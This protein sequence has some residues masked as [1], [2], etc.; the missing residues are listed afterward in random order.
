MNSL[1]FWIVGLLT[2]AL[3][4]R[5]L[6]LSRGGATAQSQTCEPTYEPL[7]GTRDPKRQFCQPHR[8]AGPGKVVGLV[9]SRRPRRVVEVPPANPPHHYSRQKSKSWSAKRLRERYPHFRKTKDRNKLR[10]QLRWPELTL[11]GIHE[12]RQQTCHTDPPFGV[13]NSGRFPLNFE[14]CVPHA[15]GCPGRALTISSRPP[16]ARPSRRQSSDTAPER[17]SGKTFGTAGRVGTSVGRNWE[18]G[19][20]E[21]LV[22]RCCSPVGHLA[23]LV[24][25]GIC[26]LLSTLNNYHRAY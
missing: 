26:H 17:R 24:E 2:S 16:C 22:R 4:S 15:N 10:A 3:P 14:R 19:L 13:G 9:Q 1:A 6:R 12:H 25:G 21:D 8:P 18:W 11:F 23:L 20:I 7:C 5:A